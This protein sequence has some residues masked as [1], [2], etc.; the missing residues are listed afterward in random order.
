VRPLV[1]V[2]TVVLNGEMY[3]EQTILSVINQTYDNVEYIIIDGGSNDSTLDI[4]RRYED[5][6]DYWVSEEDAGI[7]EAFNKGISLCRGELVGTIN[8][9]DWY[10][11]DA[12]EKVVEINKGFTVFCGHVQYWNGCE[13]DYVYLANIN[14][15]PKEMTVNHPAV[16]VSMNIYDNYGVFDSNF[17]YAMDYELLLRFYMKGVDFIEVDCVLSNMRMAGISDKYRSR[18]FKEV[19]LA[20]IHYGEPF[21]AALGYNY[22]QLIRKRISSLL[23]TIGLESIVMI[24]RSRFSAIKK[25]KRE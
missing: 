6:I 10:E 25:H 15:L 20:K 3:L 5:K 21:L 14:N 24:Y 22:W 7:A 13:K 9:D 4:I 2:I 12:I 17:K 1:S 8:A 11:Y 16:F 23:S 19:R 18:S